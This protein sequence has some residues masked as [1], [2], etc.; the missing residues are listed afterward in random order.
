M[1]VGT[2]L[3]EFNP[4]KVSPFEAKPSCGINYSP[5]FNEFANPPAGQ[6]EFFHKFWPT[7]PPEPGYLT[8]MWLKDL[9]PAPPDIG[10]PGERRRPS[11]L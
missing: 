3:P 11:L 8:A 4:K 1:V 2:S 6:S 7:C 5:N 10:V 9:R